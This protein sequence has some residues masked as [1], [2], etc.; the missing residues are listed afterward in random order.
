[1][2]ILEEIR[3]CFASL[4]PGYRRLNSTGEYAT[5]VIKDSGLYGVALPFPNSEIISEKFS[6]CRMISKDMFID[7]QHGTYI[8]LMCDELNLRYEFAS[9]CAHF[10]DPGESGRE[11]KKII[12]DPRNWWESW[13][14]LLGNKISEKSAS[15][16]IAEMLVLDHLYQRDKSVRWTAKQNG[17]HDI[18]SDTGSFEVKSTV[19]RYGAEITITGQHQLF[20]DRKLE[21]YFVRLEKS[22]AGISIDDMKEQ[23]VA[24]GYDE[25]LLEDQLIKAGFEMGAGTRKQKYK[26][27]EKRVYTVDERFPKITNDSFVS[28]HIPE[29]IIR[30][31][32]TIDLNGIDY[33]AW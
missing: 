19:L 9:L 15:A 7:N 10:A 25:G 21:L 14:K 11:R 16:E 28:G 26:T 22:S 1:M 18:E 2:D 31:S 30:I 32:Y 17:S 29:S 13:C 27:L 12:A 3:D 5:Y 4:Q 8:L 24:H 33:N 6:S 20:S 23:L